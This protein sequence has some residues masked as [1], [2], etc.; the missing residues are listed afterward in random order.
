MI[1]PLAFDFLRFL[2]EGFVLV[3]GVFS[4]RE[5]N[6][7]RKACDLT[8]YDKSYSDWTIDPIK[9]FN[10]DRI[11][12]PTGICALDKLT[13]NNGLLDCFSKLL[14][15]PDPRLCNAHVFVRNGYTDHELGIVAN[16]QWHIDHN[17]DSFLPPH[18]DWKTYA[19]VN[20]HIFLDEVTSAHAPMQIVPGSHINVSQ[21]FSH[22]SNLGLLDS[23]GNFL[24]ATELWSSKNVC[25]TAP[26]GAVLFY[27]SLLVHR[28]TRFTDPTLQRPVFTCTM[29]NPTCV[30][31]KRHSWPYSFTDR[32]I[33][34]EF[35]AG[36]TSRLRTALG[37]PPPGHSYYTPNT[38]DSLRYWYPGID[39]R[40]YE[41]SDKIEK[42]E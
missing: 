42:P 18:E 38:L 22:Y 29:I 20:C 15:T 6:L 35:C 8:V 16:G 41:R 21:E 30:G 12:F 26:A 33:A 32:R 9:T 23:P 17:T 27:S 11:K 13:A 4:R 24:T 5:I 14:G 19:Y 3:E 34:N 28:A 25:V 7:A 40:E 37:W 1:A 10:K 36:T 2:E 39:L 31:W